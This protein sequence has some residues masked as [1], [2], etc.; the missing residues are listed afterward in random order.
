MVGRWV[1]DRA[2]LGGS[3]KEAEERPT[4]GFEEV[5]FPGAEPGERLAGVTN[6]GAQNPAHL[7]ADQTEN[8]EP[9]REDG[10]DIAAENAAAADAGVEARERAGRFGDDN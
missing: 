1:N 2:W 7:R 5:R 8:D 4:D 9:A 6:K 3:I 10:V